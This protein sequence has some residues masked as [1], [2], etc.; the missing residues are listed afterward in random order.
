V[1][2]RPQA[3]RTGLALGVASYLLW[4]FLPLYLR[5]LD[6][7]GPVEV[8]AHRVIWTLV[9]CLVIVL[10]LR[11][12]RELTAALRDRRTMAAL[13]TSGA[14]L[15]VNWLVFVYAVGS[16]QLAEAS[17]GY[18]INPLITVALAVVFLRER[19]RPVQWVAL[20]IGGSAVVVVWS[21]IGRFPWIA[22]TL[23][24][25][26]GFY[27]YVEKR[28]GRAVAAP[29]AMSVETI[30]VLP[31]AVVY[32]TWLGARGGQNFAGLGVWHSLAMAGV[33]LATAVPL[34]LYNGAARRMPLSTLGLL[35][36]MC[37]LMQFLTALLVFHEAMT[38]V[39]WIGFG[40]V[41]VALVVLVTDGV[42][43]RRRVARGVH[44]A[45]P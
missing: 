13:A 19:L 21:G 37:P 1:T 35:Q 41:W 34:L 18:F 20:A 31:I 33:G 5:L 8:I 3:S 4:G 10:L 40:L 25:S 27:S 45:V 42:V 6:P 32:L 28:V 26:F 23:G 15:F 17:L 2:P 29:V 11:R 9:V 43:A 7:A 39:S 14:L 36:Y 12:S 30:A 44:A 38:L 16:D 24:F 22:L